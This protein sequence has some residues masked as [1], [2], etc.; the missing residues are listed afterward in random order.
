M[1]TLSAEFIFVDQI[2]NDIL[3]AENEDLRSLLR[4]VNPSANG[5]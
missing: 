2:Q 5:S 4:K 3:A 1:T